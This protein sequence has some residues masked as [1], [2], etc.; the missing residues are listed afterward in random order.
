MSSYQYF[1]STAETA[2][3]ERPGRTQTKGMEGF[4]FSQGC[5][6]NLRCEKNVLFVLFF[7]SH[8]ISLHDSFQQWVSL[9]ECL[10]GAIRNEGC[11][12]SFFFLLSFLEMTPTLRGLYCL[13]LSLA[14]FS[15][16]SAIAL[17]SSIV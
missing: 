17:L 11:V 1:F 8:F 13:V 4:L 12:K 7:F 10:S 9:V 5:C 3:M 16:F 6:P 14:A 2:Q 15:C